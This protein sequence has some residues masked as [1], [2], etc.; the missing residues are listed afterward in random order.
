VHFH[1]PYT[2]GKWARDVG[3]TRRRENS[4]FKP[5]ALYP[6]ASLLSVGAIA[7]GAIFDFSQRS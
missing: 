6:N 4:C 1:C 7:S 5:L 3:S 2:G